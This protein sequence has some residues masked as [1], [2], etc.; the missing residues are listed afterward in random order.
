MDEFQEDLVA[1]KGCGGRLFG[2]FIL[3]FPCK[4]RLLTFE[5]PFALQ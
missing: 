5:F 3:S 2:F 4:E 1:K